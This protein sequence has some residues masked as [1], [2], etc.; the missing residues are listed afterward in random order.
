M[1]GLPGADVPNADRTVPGSSHQQ[2]ELR[3][4]G[5]GVHAAQVA[6]VVA[7]DGVG[8]KVPA[9]HLVLVTAREKVRVAV[10]YRYGCDVM[11]KK[12]LEHVSQGLT[13]THGN[14]K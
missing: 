11:E 13:I 9:H 4:Q 7:H 12:K 3:V 5:K 2:V 8:L 10:G 1:D 6:V 14:R